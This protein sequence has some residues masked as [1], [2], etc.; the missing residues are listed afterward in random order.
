MRLLP[1]KQQDA[2]LNQVCR[3]FRSFSN[4]KLDDAGDLGP[5]GRSVRIIT[6][7]QEGAYGWIAVNYL[8]DGF[9][10]NPDSQQTL[11]FLDMG[12]ASTQ[13]AFEPSID[14][15][16]LQ[17]VR[18]RLLNGKDINHRV[19]V[20]T[21]LG[22]GTN[23]ARQRYVGQIIEQ[24]EANRK[25]QNDVVTDPCLPKS[26]QRTEKPVNP[27]TTNEHSLS[28]HI[29][30][31]GGNFTQCLEQTAPLL[32]KDAPCL[33][34]PCLFG[35][36]YVPSI[37]FSVSQFVGVSEYWYS[38]EH[39][40]GLGGAYDFVQYG[41]A[42][43]EFC[44]Q[45]WDTI[46]ARHDKLRK[47]GQVEGDGEVEK[48]GKVVGTGDWSSEVELARLQLLCFKA[49]WIVNVLHE[50][51]GLPRIVDPGG[52]S[53][54]KSAI[55]KVDENA[56]S[57][58]L[59]RP[60]FQS[61]DTVGDTAISWTLGKIVLEASKE[62]E[63]SSNVYSP[64]VD[65]YD[66]AL[67]AVTSVPKPGIF[68]IGYLEDKVSKH[69]PSSLSR[70][71]YGISLISLLFY[72][73]V[74]GLFGMV[75]YRF[76]SRFRVFFRRTIRK[77][78]LRAER[79]DRFLLQ[80]NGNTI[81]SSSQRPALASLNFSLHKFLSRITRTIR[82]VHNSSATT[83]TQPSNYY[84]NGSQQTDASYPSSVASSIRARPASRSAVLSNGKQFYAD[85]EITPPTTPDGSV[86]DS[87]AMSLSGNLSRSRNSS[88]INLQSR[89]VSS[90]SQT[91]TKGFAS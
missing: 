64:L 13:I 52:N 68:D 71:I 35:G 47:A 18:L 66:P 4:F 20:T 43:S 30:T 81:D 34:K 6:G 63:P 73:M 82:P 58:G 89:L 37:D 53:T 49:A 60:S 5:C 65:P 57:K 19:F 1:L 69:L 29:L 32:N 10:T 24:F 74:F 62:I 38:S 3:Y 51:L 75:F 21:W 67:E 42:A 40:F 9:S 12:G 77:S 85:R 54:D 16:N 55:H 27:N 31:G 23:Q 44:M 90:R 45:E 61:A 11:G 7:E 2:I 86:G 28:S 22:Y 50:G 79:E 80:E 15:K 41:R 91:P 72:A 87:I 39:V 25:G 88:V 59:G 48:D 14:S 76:R 70:D 83:P 56:K 36:K 33:E 26:L 78:A 46:V 84:G 8:M 17:D